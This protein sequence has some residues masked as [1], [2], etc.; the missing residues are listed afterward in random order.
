MPKSKP[1]R[2]PVKAAPAALPTLALLSPTDAAE[3]LGVGRTK[4]LELVRSGRIACRMMD[5]RIRIPVEAL[6]AFRD[7][8]PAG[9]VAGPPVRKPVA[10]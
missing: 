4:L 2:Q 8:L 7:A 9:Y 10:S 5:N 3:T 6:Q 1:S